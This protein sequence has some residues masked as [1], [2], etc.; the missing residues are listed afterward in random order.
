MSADIMANDKLKKSSALNEN[1]NRLG[2]IAC[3]KFENVLDAMAVITNKVSVNLP[4]NN[5]QN[6]TPCI[7]P[8]KN[9]L[10]MLGGLD[11]EAALPYGNAGRAF[12][13]LNKQI[14]SVTSELRNLFA[15]GNEKNRRKKKGARKGGSKRA[16][17]KR[18]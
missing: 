9:L 6:D 14:E 7:V 11:P 17:S 3:V 12:N 8:S 16:A 2:R 10:S 18:A 13:S 5:G 1:L 15:G 4:L